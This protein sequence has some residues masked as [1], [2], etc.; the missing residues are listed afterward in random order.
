MYTCIGSWPVIPT[1][2]I[3]LHCTLSD[4][5]RITDNQLKTNALLNNHGV[6][7]KKMFMN[8]IS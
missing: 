1:F 6:L 2:N 3:N 8:M 7:E 4:M 5:V